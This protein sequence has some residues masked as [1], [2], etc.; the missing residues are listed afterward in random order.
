MGNPEKFSID[1]IVGFYEG[2]EIVKDNTK[3]STTTAYRLGRLSDY[4]RAVVRTFEKTKEKERKEA[5]LKINDLKKG[6]DKADEEQ[7]KLVDEQVRDINNAFVE[8]I[9]ELAEQ[10]E[11]ISVPEFKLEDFENKDVPVKFFSLLGDVIKE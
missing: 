4:C 7:K 5:A 1:K 11:Q 8:K 2:I 9:N 10:E 3:L 6:Y